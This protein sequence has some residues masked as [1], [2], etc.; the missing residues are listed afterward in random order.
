MT[1]APSRVRVN[2]C[3]RVR[4]APDWAWDTAPGLPDFDLITVH[5]GRGEYRAGGDVFPARAGTCLLLRPGVRY[6]GTTDPGDPMTVT[7]VHFDYL[8]TRGRRTRP[9]EGQ[10]PAPGRALEKPGFFYELL[11]RLLA[12]GREDR[13]AE[14]G[15]WLSAA[16][17]ELGLQD[18]RPRWS[19]QELE[20][21]RAVEGLCARIRREP[22]A[23]W[24]VA[25]M[26]R[27]LFCTA[28]HFARLFRKYAG[29]APGEFVVRARI[30][31]AMGLL[32]SSSQSVTRIAELLGYPDVCAFSRQFKQKTG[33]TPTAYRRG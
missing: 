16:L 3:G 10:L 29:S 12:A 2:S 26:S 19:G 33:A 15:L 6:L 9:V 23:R 18:R 1:F 28:D 8:G 17:S 30:D 14:S 21:A 32:R 5:G 25:E 4:C 7:W 11:D 27:R 22:G 13:G 20:Q 24:R 31:A